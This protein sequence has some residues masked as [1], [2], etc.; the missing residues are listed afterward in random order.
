M[1]V[2]LL[3]ALTQKPLPYPYSILTCVDHSIATHDPYINWTPRIIWKT[4]NTPS[5]ELLIPHSWAP[6]HCWTLPTSLFAI[7][8]Q[9]QLSSCPDPDQTCMHQDRPGLF[10]SWFLWWVKARI[11]HED[12]T[13][14]RYWLRFAWISAAPCYH[15]EFTYLLSFYLHTCA[16]W[17]IYKSHENA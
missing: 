2:L 13:H 17:N 4:F 9:I 10:F 3:W 8:I 1:V 11:V 6:A 14:F 16:D 15:Q 7:I 12:V 5:Q